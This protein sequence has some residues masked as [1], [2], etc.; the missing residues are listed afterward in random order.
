MTEIVYWH[1]NEQ[2]FISLNA[3][4]HLSGRFYTL[5]F[6]FGFP[7]FVFVFCLFKDPY[8]MDE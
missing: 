6:F 8:K 4:T 5:I 7:F 2:Q 3:S 1:H